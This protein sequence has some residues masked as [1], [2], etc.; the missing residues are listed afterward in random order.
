MSA[1]LTG[2]LSHNLLPQ[3][4]GGLTTG[5]G[6]M[7]APSSVRVTGTIVSTNAGPLGLAAIF[8]SRAASCFGGC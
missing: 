8:I 7:G 4:G 6:P 5:G 2:D 3:V 1:F